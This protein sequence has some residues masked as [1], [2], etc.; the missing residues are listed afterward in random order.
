MLGER[1]GRGRTQPT[2]YGPQCNNDT[3]L[4]VT[5]LGRKLVVTSH[6]R[7]LVKKNGYY[8]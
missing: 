7:K 3:Y 6:E 5:S 2:S 1:G 4:D 8:T